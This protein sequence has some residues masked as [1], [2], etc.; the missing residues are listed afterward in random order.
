MSFSRTSEHLEFALKANP[1]DEANIHALYHLVA[2]KSELPASS[3]FASLDEAKQFLVELYAAFGWNHINKKV[4]S[5]RI[6]RGEWR[7]E[8]VSDQLAKYQFMQSEK[9]LGSKNCRLDSI[10]YVRSIPYFW[11]PLDYLPN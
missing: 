5:I 1:S 10:F 4:H 11:H 3:K 8:V 7:I 6:K 2:A 9:H